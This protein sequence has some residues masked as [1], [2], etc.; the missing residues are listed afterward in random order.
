MLNGID[1]VLIFN[2]SKLLPGL[3]AAVSGVPY[4][5][6]IVDKIGFAPIPIYLSETLTGLYI[7]SEDK[8]VEIETS[9]E[10]TVDGKSPVVN[11]KGIQSTVR[12]NMIANQDS[13]GMTLLSTL[14]DLLFEKVTS[15]EY[16]ISYFHNGIAI[17]Q[18]LLHSF[19]ITQGTSNTLY[20]ITLELSRSTAKPAETKPDT[21][22]VEVKKVTGTV[23]LPAGG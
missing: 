23:P 7:D 1:P 19:N 20:N 8:S 9:T 10:T 21:K 12:I 17:F 14:I 5:S 11:Q 4:V 15:K 2:L 22:I 13:L 6:K 16:S 18:G 3:D